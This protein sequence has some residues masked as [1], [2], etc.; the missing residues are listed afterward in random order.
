MWLH[1]KLDRVISFRPV[2]NVKNVKGKEK[3]YHFDRDLGL[4]F[5]PIFQWG[6]EYSRGDECQKRYE[7]I[8]KSHFIKM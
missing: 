2:Y 7:R 6:F 3:M 8:L 5:P 4:R 1:S